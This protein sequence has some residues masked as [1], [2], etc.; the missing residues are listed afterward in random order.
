MDHRQKKRKEDLAIFDEGRKRGFRTAIRA[1]FKGRGHINILVAGRSGVGKSTLLNSVFEQNFAKTGQGRP[2]TLFTQEHSKKGIPL[3]IWDTRG[4]ELKSFKECSE[5][6]ERQIKLHEK[7]SNPGRHFHIAWL[8]IPESGRRVEP[9]EIEICNMIAR[10]MPV[11][12]VIT[13]AQADNG[14]AGEVGKLLPQARKVIRVRAIS[15]VD[16]DGC[17]KKPMGL[18]ELVDFTYQM[19]PESVQAAFVSTQRISMK[20]KRFFFTFLQCFAGC[21]CIGCLGALI[22][23]A[24]IAWFVWRAF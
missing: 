17:E 2:V 5:T 23:M 24:C 6:L 18:D 16:D 15:T 11:I 7:E 12:C 13:K 3:T 14:F 19:I 4:L 22:L 10:H 1:A 21:A 8:C 9:G 20:L